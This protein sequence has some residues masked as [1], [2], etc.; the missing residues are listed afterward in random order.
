MDSF[1][2]KNRYG[3]GDYNAII[4]AYETELPL[5]NPWDYFYYA[6]ALRKVKQYAKGREIAKEGMVAFPDFLQIRTPY[7]WCL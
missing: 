3:A 1:E 5:K 4:K 6:S 2:V 7:A